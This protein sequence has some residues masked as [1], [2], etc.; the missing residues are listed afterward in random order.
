M[1]LDIKNF[2]LNAPML[3]YE[4][5]CIRINDEPEEIIK[6][7]NLREK[8][9]SEGYVYIK[10]RTGDVWLTSGRNSCTEVVGRA[11]K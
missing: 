7:Y 5:V 10:V 6:Q 1:S 2:Y 11:V 9:D 8:I 4:Y 3:R